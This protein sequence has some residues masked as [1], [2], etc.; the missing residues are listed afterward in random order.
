MLR[1]FQVK[2][3]MAASIITK[4]D[5]NYLTKTVYT[6]VSTDTAKTTTVVNAGTDTFTIVAHGWNNGDS[7][8]CTVLG[9]C[10]GIALNGEYFIVSK[11]TDTFKLAASVGGTAIDVTATVT[12]FPV[13]IRLATQTT[14]AASGDIYV[15]VTGNV[16]ALLADS[17]PTN[18]TTAVD[19]GA[20]IYK[21]VPAGT[22][23]KGPFK[24][25]FSTGTT[26]TDML[27]ITN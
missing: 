9:D 5:T 7:V 18:V 3:V 17:P 24:K 8:K 11:A 22:I 13:F 2:K 21:G 1:G 27:L 14:V 19:L 23:L 16:C 4:S 12:V 25:V 10:D 20:V 6:A 15:G 26:A